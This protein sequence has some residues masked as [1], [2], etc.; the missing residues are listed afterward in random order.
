MRRF[1]AGIVLVLV[2]AACGSESLSLSEY[3]EQ[4]MVLVMVMEEKIAALDTEWS[5]NEPTVERARRYWIKRMEAR[6][7]ALEGLEA[8]EAPE[9]LGDLLGHGLDLFVGQIEA[10]RALAARVISYETVSGPDDWWSTPEGETV[11]ALDEEINDFCRIVQARY[12]ATLE[13]AAFSDVP[14]IPSD[15][16]EWVQIDIGCR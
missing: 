4:G 12:D 9:E 1:L 6:D 3:N 5:A 11:F 15:M 14:W 10:E 7:E 13:R 16:K 2:A 8:L